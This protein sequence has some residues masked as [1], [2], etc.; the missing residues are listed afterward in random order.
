MEAHQSHEGFMLMV[1]IITLCVAIFATA[2]ILT[3]FRKSDKSHGG[4]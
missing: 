2:F 3:F 1:T 4:H